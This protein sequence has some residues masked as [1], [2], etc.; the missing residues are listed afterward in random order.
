MFLF[1]VEIFGISAQS[2]FSQTHRVPF[3]ENVVFLQDFTQM[4]R[5]SMNPG[6]D[7]AMVKT[8]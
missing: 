4:V 5:L 1:F 3:G 7:M 6:I 2:I 8:G